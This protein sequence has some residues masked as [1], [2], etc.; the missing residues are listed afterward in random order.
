MA[1]GKTVN[2]G[3][4]LNCRVRCVVDYTHRQ[5]GGQ[6]MLIYPLFITD[7]PDEE[8]PIPTPD[9]KQYNKVLGVYEGGGYVAK[10]VF[11]PWQNCTMKEKLCMA[12]NAIETLH[13]ILIRYQ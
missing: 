1:G 4:K 13:C 6:E 9:T 10:G 3:T 7:N 5:S 11:R 2:K 12:S 8:T